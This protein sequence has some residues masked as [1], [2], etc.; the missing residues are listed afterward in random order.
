MT[1]TKY[2]LWGISRNV[3]IDLNYVF[4]LVVTL[5]RGPRGERVTFKSSKHTFV[6]IMS[7][8]CVTYQIFE[9]IIKTSNKTI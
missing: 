7:G 3:S 5:E 1:D 6:F 8:Y 4:Q 9:G 2:L